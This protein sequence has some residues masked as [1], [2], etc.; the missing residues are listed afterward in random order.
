MDTTYERKYKDKQPVLDKTLSP[1][2]MQAQG[3]IQSVGYDVKKFWEESNTLARDNDMDTNL[4]YM[5]KMLEEAEGALVFNKETLADYGAKVRLF[6]GVEDWF[7][8][9]R[10][11]GKAQ[12]V[13]D[14]QVH[15][16]I[17]IKMWPSGR[18]SPLIIRTR[19]SSYFGL[20]RAF[21]TS[22]TQR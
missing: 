16:T 11:Y 3:Y 6:P 22:T 10:R 19:R 13:I 5:Y 4:A 18:H 1:D 7:E 14:T 21:W 15:S 2:D 12:G 17:T 9:I 8:R 20:K